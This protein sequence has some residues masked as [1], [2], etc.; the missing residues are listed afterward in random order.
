MEACVGMAP[1][2]SWEKSLCVIKQMGHFKKSWEEQ[3]ELWGKK[4]KNQKPTNNNNKPNPNPQINKMYAGA[5][6]QTLLLNL[7]KI[8]YLNTGGFLWGSLFLWSVVEEGTGAWAVDTCI[9]Y[10]FLDGGM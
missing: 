3:A 4:T 1:P 2:E 6:G 9:R 8:Y 7:N 5:D 10:V